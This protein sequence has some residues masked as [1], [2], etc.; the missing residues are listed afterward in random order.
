MVEP[1]EAGGRSC[2]KN[3]VLRFTKGASGVVLKLNISGGRLP[4]FY[5]GFLMTVAPWTHFCLSML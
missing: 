3:D 4:I 1:G 5:P 2:T